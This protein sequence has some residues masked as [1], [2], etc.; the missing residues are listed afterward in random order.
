MKDL[1]DLHLG[2]QTEYVSQYDASLLTPIPR[3]YGRGELGIDTEQQPFVGAD[4][5]TAYEISWLD[6]SGKPQVAIGEFIVP[7]NTTAIVESKSFK[8]YLNSF[9]QS[10]FGSWAEVTQ[11]LEQ[12]LSDCAGGPV[13]VRLFTPDAYQKQGVQILPGDSIDS[14]EAEFDCYQPNPSFLTCEEVGGLV[15]E[16][17]HSHLLKT[18]CPVTGQPDWASV[19]IRYRGK[20]LFKAIGFIP[21]T[22]H[23]NPVFEALTKQGIHV[24]SMRNKA[25]R[26]EEM[27]VSMTNQGGGEA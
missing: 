10:R 18:N 9:N 14:I 13:V 6:Q 20:H 16:T 7:S 12:D 11:I 22:L 26:L 2:K 8:L 21:H 23:M 3:S 1:S 15:S 24:Q 25:N 19:M 27:F 5:W 17:L 4:M